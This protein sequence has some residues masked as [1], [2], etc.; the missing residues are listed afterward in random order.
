MLSA[1]LWFL[2][3]L[4]ALVAGAEL[5]VRSATS[6]A[7]RFG[8]SKLVVG[9]TVVALGTSA[10]EFA[11]SIQSGL[12]GQADILM[13]NIIG[14]NISNILLILGISALILPLK[15]NV[16]LIRLDIPIMIGVT[17]LLFLFAFS[18]SI[19]VWECLAF[20][21][22]LILY[23]FLLI[24]QNRQTTAETDVKA[25]P[26]SLPVQI[27]IGLFGLILLVIG[28][29]WL[30]D[31]AV[32]FAQMAGVS[33]LVIGLTIVS[34]GTS[35]PEI[36]TSIVAVIKGERDIAVGNVVGSNIL[37]ILV[38]L[39]FTGLIV[40]GSLIV[41]PALLWFDLIILF[42]ATIACLPVFFT[43]HKIDQLEGGIFLFLYV[44]YVTFLL[45]TST[46]HSLLE[47]FT[48]TML[49]FVL[50]LIG[51]TIITMLWREFQRKY[52]F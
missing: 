10:P 7:V 36:A 32:V 50:P 3:G 24:R 4:I 18:G 8:I 48:S 20:V 45:L 34:V 12:A 39:A 47:E 9:L 49:Y 51:V 5:L 14:S 17:F 52:T 37:N 29:R 44:S 43:H 26:V 6:L 11:V 16:K 41:Q 13:G 46:E 38:V 35:L 42:A 1:I 23:L 25:L 22:T 40:P 28:A 15:V 21:G 33:E 2:I 31:S 19:S 30:V 27:I